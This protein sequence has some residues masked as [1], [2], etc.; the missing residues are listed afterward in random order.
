MPLARP[1]AF[2]PV[3]PPPANV[4]TALVA[5]TIARIRLLFLSVTKREPAPS[6]ATPVG[7]LKRATV[8]MPLVLPAAVPMLLPPPAS[9]VTCLVEMTIIRILLFLVSATYSRPAELS[10]AMPS[11]LENLATVPMPSAMPDKPEP[12]APARLETARVETLIARMALFD[13]SATYRVASALSTT[14]PRGPLNL[15]APVPSAQ[16]WL[17]GEPANADTVLVRVSTTRTMWLP[18]SQINTLSDTELAVTPRMLSIIAATPTP[19]A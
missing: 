8:P 7:A 6:R 16:A 13:E 1:A 18:S 9:V 3:L 12:H 19:L 15:A 17:P 14:R 10:S 5:M 11:G 4:E 2:P